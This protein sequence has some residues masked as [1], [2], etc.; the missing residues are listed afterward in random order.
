MP[1]K[2]MGRAGAVL[3]GMEGLRGGDAEEDFQGF[4]VGWLLSGD[5]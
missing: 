5:L 1:Q 2:G 3:L 4:D